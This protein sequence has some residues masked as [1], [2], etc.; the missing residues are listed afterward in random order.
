MSGIEAT[1]QIKR[2]YPRVQIVILSIFE[3]DDNVF[4]AICA[5]ACG[6]LSKP[7]MPA[8]LLEAVEQAFDGAFPMSPPIARNVLELFK[9]HVPPTQADYSLT[10]HELKVL[11]SLA[12]GD[13][14]KLIAEKLSLSPSTVRDHLRSIYDKLHVHSKSRGVAK[15]L[16]Q[17]LP[18]RKG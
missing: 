15:A 16:H 18:F 3:D 5:G 14:H 8:Q 6:Y 17:R 10:D 1:V 9:K 13:D 7:V 11:E 2:S 12:Q 4:E